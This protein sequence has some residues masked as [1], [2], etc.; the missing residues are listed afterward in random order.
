MCVHNKQLY[1]FC[2]RMKWYLYFVKKVN[3][4]GIWTIQLYQTLNKKK[5]NSK[6][7]SFWC[8]NNNGSY[9]TS[10]LLYSD[11]A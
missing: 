9:V 10:L 4:K 2:I 5:V 1:F 8:W 6:K 3:H 11:L 7:A